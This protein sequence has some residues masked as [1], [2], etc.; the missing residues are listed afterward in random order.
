MNAL[1]L[2]VMQEFSQFPMGGAYR[3]T[4]TDCTGLWVR[5]ICCIRDLVVVGLD[6]AHRVVEEDDEVTGDNGV[7]LAF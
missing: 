1:Q 2:A 5:A 7:G 6:P 3:S 4:K